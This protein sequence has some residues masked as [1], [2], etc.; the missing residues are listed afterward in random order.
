MIH[1][2]PSIANNPFKRTHEPRGMEV[3][4]E[5]NSGSPLFY[6]K[7]HLDGRVETKYHK[8]LIDILD[9]VFR[10][11]G[12]KFLSRE[13]ERFLTKFFKYADKISYNIRTGKEDIYE[14]VYEEFK[15]LDKFLGSYRG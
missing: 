8:N 12:M 1:T 9:R 10:F 15:D 14:N 3:L 7:H 5:Y 11:R 6:K 4:S 13:Q 2:F